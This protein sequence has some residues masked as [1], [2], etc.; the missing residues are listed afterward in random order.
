[1]IPKYN[2][3][4]WSEA[5]VLVKILADGELMQ[6]N[7]ILEPLNE[8]PYKVLSVIR[9]DKKGVS[10]QYKRDTGKITVCF[11]EG[12]DLSIG[13]DKLQENSQ[14]ILE[15]IKSSKGRSFPLSQDLWTFL[16]ELSVTQIKAPSKDKTDIQVEIRDHFSGIQSLLGFSI[17]SQ[18]GG[19]STLVN[20]SK[21]TNIQFQ[22]KCDDSLY[23]QAKKIDKGKD[24]V[25]FLYENN[26]PIKFKKIKSPTFSNNLRLL[27]ADLQQILGECLLAYYSS[28][29]SSLVKTLANISS[30]N[31]CGFPDNHGV[32]F[33]SYKL[34]KYLT[35][36]ALGMMPASC[37][38][39]KHDATGGYIV[40]KESGE[41]L[42]YHLLR[43]NLFEDYLLEN[44]KFDTPSTSRYD[45]GYIYKDQGLFYID[46]NLQIRFKK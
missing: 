3:G 36:S 42:S 43:K 15:E 18:L 34:K 23:N 44:T 31:P 8:A 39:G 21:T 33:Y 40:V 7:D 16:N 19:A 35:E 2:K 13:V 1:M 9:S 24:T 4:E 14:L 37:W 5:Y 10:K 20:P 12:P 32:S 6:G 17:K 41:L 29:G 45:F 38:H 27:D 30:Q 22:V 11:P 26:A 28:N 25:K 46:L